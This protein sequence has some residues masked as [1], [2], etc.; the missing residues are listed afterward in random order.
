VRWARESPEHLLIGIPI[1]L[2]CKEQSMCNCLRAPVYD[3]AARFRVNEAMLAAAQERARL[4]GMTVS[5][6]F[7]HALR[8][9]L[10]EAA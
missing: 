9:E 10:S 6:L 7:R 1:N 2:A 3:T 8:R 4:Q 5:E